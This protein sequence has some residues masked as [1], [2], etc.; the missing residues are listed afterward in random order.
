MRMLL[1]WGQSTT[2]PFA[3]IVP[4]GNDPAAWADAIAGVI[5]AMKRI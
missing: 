4:N 2:G 5:E 1:G 3:A